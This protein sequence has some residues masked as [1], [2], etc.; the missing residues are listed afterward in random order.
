MR[1]EVVGDLR[2]GTRSGGPDLID[3]PEQRAGEVL[4]QQPV[5]RGVLACDHAVL[6][7]RIVEDRRHHA[8]DLERILGVVQ[9]AAAVHRRR[10]RRR[11]VSEDRDL[12]V[13]AL[14]ER[15][16]EALV[17]A[18]AQEEVR[19]V[20]QRG[21]LLVRDV[22]EEVDVR[23]AEPRDQRVQ[24]RQVFLEAAVGA[25]QQQSRAR[26]VPRAVDVEG[27]DDVLELLVRDHPAHEHDVGPAVVERPGGHQVGRQIEMREVGDDRQHA[28][29][30]ESEVFE[31]LPVVFGVAERQL[32]ARDVGR[33]ARAG[34][35][36]R[37]SRDPCGRRGSTRAA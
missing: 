26:I 7:I 33:R 24:H 31:L 5:E 8:R 6:E 37:A 19:H 14:D 30:A 20:V 2:C 28:G 23:R 21:E 16:A 3:E 25:D 29:R 36:S 18:G 32:A 34:R 11:G 27:A 22:A 4:G 10:H 9:H 35:G 17:L 12:L 15:D 13:E 1:P